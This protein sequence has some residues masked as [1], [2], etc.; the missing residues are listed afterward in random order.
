M[1]GCMGSCCLEQLQLTLLLACERRWFMLEWHGACMLMQTSELP[2]G[3]A[4]CMRVCREHAQLH[5]SR[6]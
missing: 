5:A 3:G 4:T 2:H 6:G 1:V